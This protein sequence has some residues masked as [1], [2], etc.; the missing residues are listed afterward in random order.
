MENKENGSVCLYAIGHDPDG[1]WARHFEIINE[2]ILSLPLIKDR[3]V[4]FTLK[5]DPKTI[6]E[7][8]KFKNLL[9]CFCCIFCDIL[10]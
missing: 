4:S 6:N 5:T 3:Q 9:A 8:E 1:K 7:A 2:P 10:I